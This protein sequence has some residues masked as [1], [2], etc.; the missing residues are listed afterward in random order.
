MPVSALD[1]CKYSI[2]YR[3]LHTNEIINSTCYATVKVESTLSWRTPFIVQAALG[4]FLS[5]S[6]FILPKSPRWLLAHGNREKAIRELERL[7]FSTVEAEKDLLGPAAEQ[8]ISASSRRRPG[9]IEGLVMIFRKPYRKSTLLALYVLGM[10]QLS[11]IDGVLYV[12]S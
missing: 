12:S 9:P 11:G 6:R 1:T 10:V 2:R 7:D 3:Q 8:Q 5:T 4:A